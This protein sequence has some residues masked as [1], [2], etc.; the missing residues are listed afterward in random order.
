MEL[1]FLSVCSTSQDGETKFSSSR[2]QAS[3]VWVNS[4]ILV[5]VLLHMTTRDS[6]SRRN[7]L[8]V[9]AQNLR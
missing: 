6:I 1:A 8:C 4:S 9:L 7:C 2:G 5:A 3:L